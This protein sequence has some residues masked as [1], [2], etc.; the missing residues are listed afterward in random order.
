MPL[1]ANGADFLTETF[2][3]QDAREFM[4]ERFGETGNAFSF[5]LPAMFGMS[6]HGNVAAPGS[7]LAHD[8]EFF[9]SVM[10]F[11]RA[12]LMG[13]AMGRAWDD[14]MVL[15]QSPISDP[16]FRGSSRRPLRPALCI[17]VLKL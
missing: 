13:R 12:K 10:A 11:E 8:T 7:N 5:G 16:L 17:G 1:I 4:F 9:F 6:L 14:A 3:D 2:A 15:G